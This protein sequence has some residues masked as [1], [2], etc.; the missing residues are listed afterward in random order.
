MRRR[1]G[2]SLGL[3]LLCSLQSLN[4]KQAARCVA[5]GIPGF[6]GLGYF[7][8]VLQWGSST[9]LWDWD[10][11]G[12]HKP[13]RHGP[14]GGHVDPNP[15][16]FWSPKANSKSKST[17][18]SLEQRGLPSWHSMYLSEA[19]PTALHHAAGYVSWPRSHLRKANAS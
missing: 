10:P 11:S 6:L 16:S 8:Q 9:S 2:E 3:V 15:D 7:A 14:F 13:P 19:T 18:S 5:R 1:P 17:C 4:A 12:P